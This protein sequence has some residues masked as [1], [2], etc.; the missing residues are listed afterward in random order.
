[1]SRTGKLQSVLPLNVAR[2]LVT[3]GLTITT[4]THLAVLTKRLS[5]TSVSGGR[6]TDPEQGRAIAAASSVLTMVLALY[7]ARTTRSATE[8]NT[9]DVTVLRVLAGAFALSVPIQLLGTR[10]ERIAMA[11]TAGLYVFRCNSDVGGTR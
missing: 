11:P 1:M 6:V 9:K 4:L 3:G 7:P 10:F 8:P 5:H 2:M